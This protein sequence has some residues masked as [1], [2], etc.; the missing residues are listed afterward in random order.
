MECKTDWGYKEMLNHHFESPTCKCHQTRL[1]N[2][3]HIY[4]RN[5]FSMCKISD[6]RKDLSW[7]TMSKHPP[8]MWA[9]L[10]HGPRCEKTCLRKFA[11]NN[12]ADQ[13]AHTRSLISAFVIRLLQSI[14]SRLAKSEISNFNFLASLCSWAGCLVSYFVGNPNDRFS[15]GEAQM[16]ARK[17]IRK[18]VQIHRLIWAL[19]RC[20]GI[21]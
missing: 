7:Q 20:S 8:L 12:G 16:S 17:S 21:Q 4:P 19:N 9:I 3:S 5:F 14:T 15:H 1:R 2:S 10:V 11:N 6:L 18:T 13:P